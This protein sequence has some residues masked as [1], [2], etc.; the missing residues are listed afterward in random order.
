MNGKALGKTPII[1]SIESLGTSR[2]LSETPEYSSSAQGEITLIIEDKQLGGA[3]APD[4]VL[5]LKKWRGYNK[6]E[7]ED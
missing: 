1:K 4:Y 7:N 3:E 6:H 5:V 2:S